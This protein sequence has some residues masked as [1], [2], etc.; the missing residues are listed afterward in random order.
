MVLHCTQGERREEDG[1][2]MCTKRRRKNVRREGLS[3][4]EGK[5]IVLHI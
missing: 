3:D 5:F 1:G 4:L 2:E